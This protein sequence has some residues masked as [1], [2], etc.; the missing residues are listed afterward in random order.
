MEVCKRKRFPYVTQNSDFNDII[1][2]N[3]FPPKIIRINAGNTT[4]QKIIELIISNN[5]L[6]HNFLD[7]EKM[8]YL[9]ID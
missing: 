4:T 3:G 9:E 8:G 2:L 1:F 7:N 5:D 6:I